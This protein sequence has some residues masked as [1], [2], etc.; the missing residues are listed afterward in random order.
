MG[1]DSARPEGAQQV[2]Q[3]KDGNAYEG[4][5]DPCR[6]AEF[7]A[8]VHRGEWIGCEGLRCGGQHRFFPLRFRC[9]HTD[10]VHFAYG[11]ATANRERFVT[12]GKV[13]PPACCDAE[14][15]WSGLPQPYAHV[16]ARVVA[17]FLEAVWRLQLL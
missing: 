13:E 14:T 2:I 17:L 3:D 9:S 7:L 6:M 11:T 1:H 15:Y 12:V 4:V 8:R 16:R 5:T 10:Q